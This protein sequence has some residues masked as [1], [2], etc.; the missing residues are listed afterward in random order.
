MSSCRSASRASP[1]VVLDVRPGVD[2]SPT[3]AFLAF[4][5]RAGNDVNILRRTPPTVSSSV[6]IRRMASTWK[7]RITCPGP[8]RQLEHIAYTLRRERTH[9]LRDRALVAKPTAYAEPAR[10]GTT[11]KIGWGATSNAR[12]VPEWAQRQFRIYRRA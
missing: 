11:P 1:H 7:Q 3:P 10:L 12:P 4:R 5:L 2:L 6:A 9:T 8:H